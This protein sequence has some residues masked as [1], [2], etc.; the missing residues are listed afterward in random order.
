[1]ILYII[2]D[3]DY[4]EETEHGHIGE[5]GWGASWW[6]NLLNK[7]SHENTELCVVLWWLRDLSQSL[8]LRNLDYFF[9]LQA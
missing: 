2:V 1:M 8:I 3:C 7:Q 4:S 6:P 5:H 9:R